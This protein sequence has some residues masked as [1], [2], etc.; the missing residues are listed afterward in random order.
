MMVSHLTPYIGKCHV[1]CW[2]SPGTGGLRLL[3]GDLV[4]ASLV[5]PVDDRVSQLTHQLGGA[6]TRS[7]AQLDARRRL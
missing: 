3:D 7:H 5:N 4:N 2:W 1:I 6:N